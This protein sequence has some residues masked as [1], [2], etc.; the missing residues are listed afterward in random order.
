VQK[1]YLDAVK[2]GERDVTLE[3]IDVAPGMLPFRAV[4]KSGGG[5]VRGTVENGDG[6]IVALVPQDERLRFGPFVVAAFFS[7]AAFSVEHVRPGDYYAFAL[8][9]DFNLGQMQDPAYAGPRLAGAA[10]VRVE[11]GSP[12]TATLVYAKATS[13]Q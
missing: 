7:G 10:R 6:G 8:Q 5:Q 12:A 9:G 1:F 4:L 2:L 13:S 11:E 3:W